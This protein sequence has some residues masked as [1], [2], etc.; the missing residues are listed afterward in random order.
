MVLISLLF[1]FGL[2]FLWSPGCGGQTMV[3]LYLF[4]LISF[5]LGF[6]IYT[7]DFH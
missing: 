1:A 7:Y 2:I 4:A 6:N 5:L 3:L